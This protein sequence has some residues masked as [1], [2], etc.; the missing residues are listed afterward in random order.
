MLAASIANAITNAYAQYGLESRLAMVKNAT[1]WLSERLQNLKAQLEQSEI[2][3]QAFQRRESMLNSSNR[4]Q[5]L[6]TKMANLATQLINAQTQRAEL[7]IRY[8]Q[9]HETRLEGKGY[10]ILVPLSNNMLVERLYEQFGNLE[11]KLSELGDRYGD[12]HP[13]M[14]AAKADRDESERRLLAEINRVSD[15]LHKDFIA[16]Q[17]KEQEAKRQ[18]DLMQQDMQNNT[19]KGF[20]QAKLEREVE[21]NRQ[22]YETF[23]S[24]FKE[25]DNSGESTQLNVRI[26]DP[27]LVPEVPFKPKKFLILM[28]SMLVGLVVGVA[29]AVLR[30]FL[31]NTFKRAADIEEKLLL[32][33]LSELVYLET[34]KM[35]DVSP[36]RHFI[37]HP[38]SA[39]AETI[40]HVRTGIMF[41]DLDEPVKS[42]LVT[43]A[44]PGEGKTTLSSNLAISF[45]QLGKT[46]LIDADMRKPSIRRA[47]GKPQGA[48]LSEWI[49]G[50]VDLPQAIHQDE[51]IPNLSVMTTGQLPPNPLELL[52]S[53]KFKQRFDILQNEYDYII[54]D[55][56]PIL[57]VSDALVLGNLVDKVILSV[58]FDVTTFPLAEEAVKR[59]RSNHIEPLGAVLSMVDMKKIKSYYGSHYY[60]S[61]YGAYYG[62]YYGE[63]ACA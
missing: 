47:H 56:P 9:V 5:M 37:Q 2:Q 42:L 13:K 1:S 40:N 25:I 59:L 35:D 58:R 10:E 32:P 30:A 36:E 11:R 22:L 24:R 15:S 53:A 49:S 54:F 23:L 34:D 39:F 51:V 26:V 21:S 20:Q 3:L 38:R 28:L 63:E 16:A 61:Y 7:E 27:A 60:Q 50:S 45:A 55:T 18:L 46:L 57:P 17:A 44:Q 29:L 4:R 43:S 62:K 48:G 12:K 41:S 33:V 6:D 52:S 8:R 31:D 14:I 19:G